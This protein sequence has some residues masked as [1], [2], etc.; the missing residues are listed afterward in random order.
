MIFLPLVRYLVIVLENRENR[1]G[2]KSLN[3]NRWPRDRWLGGDG[4]RP[5]G[6]SKFGSVAPV[7]PAA[8]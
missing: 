7:I 4:G 2:Y 6:G 1:K 3:E 8:V 5:E